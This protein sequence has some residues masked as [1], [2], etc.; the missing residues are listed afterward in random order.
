METKQNNLV[1]NF[2]DVFTGFDAVIDRVPKDG[3]DW[4]EKG[5]EWTIREVVHHVAEDCNVYAFII[6]RA[7]ATPGC[8]VI[9]GEFPGNQ[10]WGKA[11]AWHTR[12]VEPARS[13]MHAHRVYL[14]DLLTSLPDLWENT[15][16]FKDESGKELAE[17]NVIQ[18]TGMLTE[19]MDEHTEMIEK[20][21]GANAR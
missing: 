13:L 15:V 12:P 3:L 5:G 21:I 18:M 8:N 7:L 16:H 17:Q 1:Q 6:E 11:L 20:I 14:A 19:H 10:P 2:L 4:A 9:F